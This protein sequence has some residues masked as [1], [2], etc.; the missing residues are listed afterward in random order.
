[1]S[2]RV[3][4]A[5][6][7]LL[8]STP[9]PAES[10]YVIEQLVVAVAS[11]P[12]ASGERVA[13]LRS[14]DRVEVLERA[15]EQV[16]VR[17][18]GGR[19][20]WVRASYLSSEEP[21]RVRLAQRD[22]EVARLGEEVNGLKA[23]LRTNATANA[24]SRPTTAPTAPT[25][26]TSP[27]PLLG[28]SASTAVTSTAQTAGEDPAGMAPTALFS[29]AEERPRVSWPWTLATGLVAFGVGFGLGALVLDRHIR[30]KYGGLR[31]Y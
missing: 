14:G 30:R 16:H 27:T 29:A 17:L 23:Q 9:L 7:A 6:A 22:A 21:L 25:S 15:G 28:V 24:A 11:A 19:E 3:A 4:L 13:T 10:L 8:V 5:F 2:P 12:D 1:M 26:P 20:G 18:A 31:I